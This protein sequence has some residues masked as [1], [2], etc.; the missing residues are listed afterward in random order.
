MNL[1]FF[2]LSPYFWWDYYNNKNDLRRDLALAL[3]QIEFLNL[4]EEFNIQSQIV[5]SHINNTSQLSQDIELLE[6]YKMKIKKF[7]KILR[8][9]KYSLKKQIKELKMLAKLTF[10]DSYLK[11]HYR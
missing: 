2:N 4:L 8:I 3:T 1:V 5:E 6:E 9:R 7:S 10:R 11:K